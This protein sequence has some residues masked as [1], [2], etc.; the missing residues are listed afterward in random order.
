MV[1]VP[2]FIGRLCF[3]DS[4]GF[5]FT[6]LYPLVYVTNV[7]SIGTFI[8]PAGR[9][10]DMASIPRILWNILPPIGKYDMAAVIHDELY[11]RAPVINNVQVT[12]A[13][14]DAILL[15]AMEV[16]HVRW[17]QRWAIYAGVRIG[18]WKPWNAYRKAGR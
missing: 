12:R 2:R 13:M 15:E 5:P 17:D 7:A 1:Y 18:G 4:G 14:A 11:S 6:L 10:T 16:L 8:V 3:E 9:K